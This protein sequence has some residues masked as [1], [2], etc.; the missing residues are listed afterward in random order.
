MYIHVSTSVYCVHVSVRGAL[1][2]SLLRLSSSLEV[3]VRVNMRKEGKMYSFEDQKWDA[4]MRLEREKKR[5]RELRGNVE[6]AG[7]QKDVRTLVKES[8]LNQKHKVRCR[9]LL[10]QSHTDTVNQFW[11]TLGV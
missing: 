1:F 10:L 5:A 11:F 7:G 8:K 6:E 3:E 9:L 4:E 2:P